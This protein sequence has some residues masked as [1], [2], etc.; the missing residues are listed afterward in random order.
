[1]PYPAFKD[2]E[3]VSQA[4]LPVTGVGFGFDSIGEARDNKVSPHFTTLNGEWDFLLFE[5]IERLPEGIE[6]IK[7]YRGAKKITVPSDWQTKEVDKDWIKD[8]YDPYRAGVTPPDEI[9][10]VGAYHRTF[11]VTTEMLERELFLQLDGVGSAAEVYL[12]GCYIGFCQSAYDGHRFS[13]AEF[14]ALGE[15]HLTIIV[16][17]YS[18]GSCFEDTDR[19]RLSGIFRDVWLCGEPIFGV[20]D[21]KVKTVLSSDYTLGSLYVDA[22]LSIKAKHENIELWGILYNE[23]GTIVAKDQETVF[24]VSPSKTSLPLSL[25]INVEAPSLWSGE[26]PC[27]YRLVLFLQ[28]NLGNTLDLRAVQVGFREL[29]VDGLSGGVKLNGKSV[30]FFGTVYEE[31]DADTARTLTY[32]QLRKDLQLIKR[33][34]FNAI[35]L[36]Y[37]ASNR[38][39]DICDEMGLF[40]I[41]YPAIDTN[42]L[43]KNQNITAFVRD[44][45]NSMV[46]RLKNHPSIV[47]WG[48]NDDTDS[49]IVGMLKELDETRSIVGLDIEVSYE[50]SIRLIEKSAVKR[51]LS[52]TI[53]YDFID[54]EGNGLGYLG[55]YIK[56][57]NNNDFLVGGFISNFIITSAWDGENYQISIADGILQPDRTPN[58]TAFEVKQCFSPVLMELN[59]SILTVKNNHQFISLDKYYVVWEIRLDGLTRESGQVEIPQ[60]DIG[61]SVQITLPYPAIST[62]K[63]IDLVV[64]LYDAK[65]PVWSDSERSICSSYARIKNRTEAAIN[66]FVELYDEENVFSFY[67]CGCSYSIDKQTGFLTSMMREDFEFLSQPLR[68]Q[69]SRVCKK[70]EANDRSLF[71]SVKRLFKIGFWQEAENGIRLKRLTAEPTSL[72][73]EF[74]TD[75]IKSLVICY[76]CN[77]KGDLVVAYSIKSSQPA[78]RFGLTFEAVAELHELACFSLG[79]NENYKNRRMAALPVLLQGGIEE[80]C[81]HYLM[82]KENGNRTGVEW[83]MIY[84]NV[85]ND[86]KVML[87]R[88]QNNF[89]DVSVHP[90]RKEHLA[91][92]TDLDS[93]LMSNRMTVNIDAANSGIG[94]VLRKD[95]ASKPETNISYEMELIFQISRS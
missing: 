44:R 2:I 55:D 11:N 88:A 80:L 72:T 25:L 50:R 22:S 81:H 60:V 86:N 76:R 12:N 18:H 49:D 68:P 23:N 8:R 48:V 64:N 33:C 28:D 62:D 46:A 63:A 45:V 5:S 35:S 70:Q 51:T 32:E 14:I 36:R 41:S 65:P 85:K 3:F 15:N 71:N 42:G 9:N 58:P 79:P 56:C 95:Y 78:N 37:P 24:N 69:I 34:N 21:L 73:A 39:Y 30:K 61:A 93:L 90:Y 6:L 29:F 74:I 94:D 66:E 54:A 77:S 40:V 38:L 16:F 83:L 91:A 53:F 26:N 27:L 75:G 13:L 19:F 59:E 89:P 87:I 1:M 10:S 67:H 92:A 43:K 4:G 7:D 82:P 17:K 57:I 84:G 52:P 47:L 20:S 31:W